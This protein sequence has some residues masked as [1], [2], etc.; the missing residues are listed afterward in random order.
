MT[1]PVPAPAGAPHDPSLPPPIADE[2]E[3]QA[4]L[5]RMQRRA[6]ALL[7]AAAMVFLA[8][9]WWEGRYPWLG[10]VRAFGEAALV[11]VYA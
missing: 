3:K 11:G 10:Y 8:A 5:T 1:S 9:R 4:A 6:T 2:A 7:V